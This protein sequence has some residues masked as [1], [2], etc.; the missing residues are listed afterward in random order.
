VAASACKQQF[1]CKDGL[2]ALGE[3]RKRCLNSEG[4]GG[5][6]QGFAE[7]SLRVGAQEQVAELPV[8]MEFPLEPGQVGLQLADGTGVVIS[9][10]DDRVRDLAQYLT[11]RHDCTEGSVIMARRKSIAHHNRTQLRVARLAAMSDENFRA[12][13]PSL[14]AVGEAEARDAAALEKAV[15]RLNV[16]LEKATGGDASGKAVLDPRD[17]LKLLLQTPRDANLL[18]RPEG[19][20]ALA[21]ADARLVPVLRDLAKAKLTYAKKLFKPQDYSAFAARSLKLPLADVDENGAIAFGAKSPS[22]ALVWEK[23]LPSAAAAY[24]AEIAPLAERLKKK[25]PSTL[26]REKLDAE[27]KTATNACAEAE[28]SAE[29]DEGDLVECGFSG[30]CDEEVL[31]SLHSELT[32]AQAQASQA[33]LDAVLAASSLEPPPPNDWNERCVAPWW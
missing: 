26:E 12:S 9:V 21:P 28:K 17:A 32:K 31:A 18:A 23:I 3:Y 22:A 6:R 25:P 27:L 5:I 33:R 15:S 19:V 8:S 30:G 20:Q 1:E 24:A 7:L 10:C 29:R 13:Y 16:G 11:A 14:L 4:F 2:A